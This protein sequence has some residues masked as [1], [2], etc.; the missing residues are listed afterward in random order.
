M[1]KYDKV[2]WCI[3]ISGG[4]VIFYFFETTRHLIIILSLIIHLP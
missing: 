3:T 4:L 1:I 2:G